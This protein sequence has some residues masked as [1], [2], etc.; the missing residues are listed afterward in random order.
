MMPAVSD[1]PLAPFIAALILATIAGF[2]VLFVLF[3]G[4][5]VAPAALG[6]GL[7]FATPVYVLLWVVLLVARRIKR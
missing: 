5:G 3:V 1:D 4:G 7:M 2:A 6:R